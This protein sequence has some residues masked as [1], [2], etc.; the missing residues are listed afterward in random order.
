MGI[1]S[2]FSTETRFGQNREDDS[3]GKQVIGL[4]EWN[5]T[6]GLPSF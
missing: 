2:Y 3:D 6:N 4:I 1:L 5:A